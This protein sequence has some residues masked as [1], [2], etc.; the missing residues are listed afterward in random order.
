MLDCHFGRPHCISLISE[1]ILYANDEYSRLLN[2][3]HHIG[4][5]GS[6]EMSVIS[7]SFSSTERSQ[8]VQQCLE[9]GKAKLLHWHIIWYKKLYGIN[10]WESVSKLLMTRG[11]V[12]KTNS[13]S[14]NVD[15][16]EERCTQ[17]AVSHFE[18]KYEGNEAQNKV[19][20]QV[21]VTHLPQPSYVCGTVCSF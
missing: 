6:N 14:Q 19:M 7:P 1:N 16:I 20:R 18:K 2:E 21:K 15:K 4:E 5:T 17:K 10:P 8:V 3:N 13:T 12:Q 11:L 9:S